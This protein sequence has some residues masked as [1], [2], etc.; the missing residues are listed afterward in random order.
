LQLKSEGCVCFGAGERVVL[1]GMES[2]GRNL[3][4][5]VSHRGRCRRGKQQHTSIIA[6]HRVPE[7][8]EGISDPIRGMSVSYGMRLQWRARVKGVESSRMAL[9]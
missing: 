5:H 8:L 1:F 9:W 3:F 2:R 6:G 7:R 4:L